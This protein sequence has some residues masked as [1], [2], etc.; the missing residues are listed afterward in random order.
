MIFS[1][2]PPD[3]RLKEF[4]EEAIV[5]ITSA[6]A[7]YRLLTPTPPQSID[8]SRPPESVTHAANALCAIVHYLYWSPDHA[9][10]I[11]EVDSKLPTV[12]WP[13]ISYLLDHFIFRREP[14]T[15]MGFEIQNKILW[16]IPMI[17]YY[18]SQYRHWPQAQLKTHIRKVIDTTPEMVPTAFRAWLYCFEKEHPALEL[19]STTFK[20]FEWVSDPSVLEKSFV[21]VC[22]SIPNPM[23]DLL[24]FS[25]YEAT[26]RDRG[27]F[28]TLHLA[29]FVIST[30][31]ENAGEDLVFFHSFI[32][33]DGVATVASVLESLSSPNHFFKLDLRNG[34]SWITWIQC[35]MSSL[36]CVTTAFKRRS[37]LAMIQALKARLLCTM[38][39]STPIIEFDRKQYRSASL[40]R[41]YSTLLVLITPFLLYDRVWNLFMRS[42]KQITSRRGSYSAFLNSHSLKED[43]E[44]TCEWNYVISRVASIKKVRKEY[45]E[46]TAPNCANKKCPEE[47]K[48][49]QKCS[50]CSKVLYCSKSCQKY[51][52]EKHRRVCDSASDWMKQTGLPPNVNASD[53][54][55]FGWLSQREVHDHSKNLKGQ[56]KGITNPVVFIDLLEGLPVKSKDVKV[57]PSVQCPD[58][59][60]RKC[61]GPMPGVIKDISQYFERGSRFVVC[62]TLGDTILVYGFD[63]LCTG[64]HKFGKV[65]ECARLED[66]REELDKKKKLHNEMVIKMLEEIQSNLPPGMEG[67]PIGVDMEYHG[68]RNNVDMPLGDLVDFLNGFQ[69]QQPGPM[70][71]RGQSIIT[72]EMHFQRLTDYIERRRTS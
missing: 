54:H 53:S 18:P 61:G 30:L 31:S 17:M 20:M 23:R 68:Q 48:Q 11:A 46:M 13:W 64:N 60:E 16:A 15:Q 66:E 50:R 39:N 36:K 43:G 9:Y 38:V 41:R 32:L 25:G 70:D 57:Y 42:F 63:Y 24:H 55:F 3:P 37:Y 49:L 29:L 2:K 8:N 52:W 1:S 35:T 33:H 69:Q 44:V 19:H 22:S 72:D 71:H 40:S 10:T 28:N 21:H 34:D 14:S 45:R 62:F 6:H 12:I 67:I 47:S 51:D 56:F 5:E 65:D 26:Q 27:R 59:L 4:V 7:A 58:Q